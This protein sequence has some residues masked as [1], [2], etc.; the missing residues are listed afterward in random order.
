MVPILVQTCFR[1][2]AVLEGSSCELGHI[3][4]CPSDWSIAVSESIGTC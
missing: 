4:S 3:L 1:C 2:E